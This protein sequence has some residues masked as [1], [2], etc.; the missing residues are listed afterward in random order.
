MANSPLLT[1]PLLNMNF[2]TFLL[3]LGPLRYPQYELGFYSIIDA[4]VLY[5]LDVLTGLTINFR[6]GSWDNNGNAPEGN[7]L[8]ILNANDSVNANNNDK[9]LKA[10]VNVWGFWGFYE[11]G[12]PEDDWNPNGSINVNDG[13]VYFYCT[14]KIESLIMR[15]IVD[16]NSSVRLGNLKDY[17]V[18]NRLWIES[19]R[20]P[21]NNSLISIP[22]FHNRNV[23]D[24][25]VIMN[26]YH[27][28][29]GGF[30]SYYSVPFYL[31]GGTV[32]P[33]TVFPNSSNAL[34]LGNFTPF[35]AANAGTNSAYNYLLGQSNKIPLFRAPNGNT[36]SYLFAAYSGKNI[37]AF[38]IDN[39]I[40]SLWPTFFDKLRFIA[41]NN[42]FNYSLR[43]LMNSQTYRNNY[44][45]SNY[46]I[47]IKYEN[48]I[49]AYVPPA[50][51]RTVWCGDFHTRFF[52]FLR[53]Y[54]RDAGKYNKNLRWEDRP[55]TRR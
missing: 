49:L 30:G 48:R 51:R 4:Q 42:S 52:Q 47:T 37:P 22:L 29:S 45:N 23:C 25:F 12:F 10:C 43:Q 50:S 28:E 2:S 54:I 14:N 27:H 40:L 17:I 18:L 33:N 13:L 31:Y 26:M 7:I 41:S 24:R 16:Y 19:L 3:S 53:Q 34:Q 35:T 11:V 32:L 46:Q 9:L 20:S 38:S 8:R 21:V 55:V 39:R 36:I 5:L 1:M 44:N 6:K 15:D